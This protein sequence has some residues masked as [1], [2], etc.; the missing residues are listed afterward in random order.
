MSA[1][2]WLFWHRRDLRLTDNLGLAGAAA[3]SPAVTGVVVL[4]PRQLRAET[5]APA[6]LWFLR[7][8]LLELEQA[9]RAAGSRLV[10]LEGDPLE[11]VPRLAEAIGAD[12]VA[13]NRDVEPA[14]R[15]R[16]RQLAASLKA[17]GCR[18]QADWDQL[19]V[20]PEILRTGAGQ[21]YRVYGPFLRRWRA[22]LARQRL[23]NGP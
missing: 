3:V 9:W 8:S 22:Q 2:R 14:V 11:L 7:E 21:P 19:L 6:R 12:G 16:D 1:E 10:L 17:L 15:A 18:V 23:R 20:S 4:D 5:M 13:W